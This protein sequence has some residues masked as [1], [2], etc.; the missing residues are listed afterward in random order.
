MKFT[1]SID[2]NLDV[3][4]ELFSMMRPQ[5]YDRAKE[6]AKQIERVANQLRADHRRYP[7]VGLG[8]AFATHH[9]AQ[10]MVAAAQEGGEESRLIQLLS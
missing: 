8:I 9:I 3:L 5:D 10:R 7:A 1:D 6:A 2:G 4:R